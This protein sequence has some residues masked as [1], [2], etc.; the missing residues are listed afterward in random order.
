M[1]NEKLEL[2]SHTKQPIPNTF[3][4]LINKSESGHKLKTFQSY[5]HAELRKENNITFRLKLAKI[6]TRT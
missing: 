1:R 5:K 3:D 2:N 6:L 4:T